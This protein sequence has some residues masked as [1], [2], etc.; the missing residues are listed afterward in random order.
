MSEMSLLAGGLEVGPVKVNGSRKRVSGM[1]D[2][3][4]RGLVLTTN[5]N[6]IWV[7]ETDED[8]A[9]LIGKRVTVEGAPGGLD[10]LIADWVGEV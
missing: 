3:G 1:L 4:R 6:E 5:E 7:I 10:R 2:R 9:Q 8:L